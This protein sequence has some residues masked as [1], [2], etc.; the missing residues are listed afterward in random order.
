MNITI[1][2]RN[3]WIRRFG[4]QREVRGYMTNGHEDFVASLHVH[5]ARPSQGQ[6]QDEGIRKLRR[7]QAHGMVELFPADQATG[8]KGDLLLYRGTWYE[9]TS[10]AYYDHTILGH[11]NYDFVE[12]PVDSAYTIDT[13]DPPSV[14]P[15]TMK[16]GEG[17]FTPETDVPVADD[18]FLGYIKAGTGLVIDEKG[19]LS[20]DKA[21]LEELKRIL[22]G[23]T[24]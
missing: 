3:Y 1:F 23:D 10:E 20:V 5:V 16:P 12:V 19:Y 7:L 13:I 4:V 9:C 14:D 18:D 22:R 21:T 24:G 15:E 8:T 11:I 2:N 17:T 6:P